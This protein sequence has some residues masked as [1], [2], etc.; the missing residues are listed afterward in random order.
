MPMQR[1]IRA[2]AYYAPKN[3]RSAEPTQNE[4]IVVVVIRPMGS[5]ISIN[6]MSWLNLLSIV[7]ASFETWRRI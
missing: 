3:I 7:P 2:A 5:C 6:N 1:G 4:N